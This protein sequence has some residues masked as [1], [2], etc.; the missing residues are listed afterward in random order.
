MFANCKNI[1][2]INFICFNTSYIKDMSYMFYYCSNLN[3]LNLSSFDTKNVTNM[4]HIC[5]LVVIN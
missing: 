5:F 1:I 4:S 2:H 3:N